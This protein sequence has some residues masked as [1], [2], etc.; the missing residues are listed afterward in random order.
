MAM[1][2]KNNSNKGADAKEADKTTPS[3][4]CCNLPADKGR[5]LIGSLIV[6]VGLG[7]LLQNI[8]PGF[9]FNYVWPVLIV[10]FGLYMMLKGWK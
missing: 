1:K 10:I 4:G 9:N 5:I 8:I 2:Q 7:L 3:I 6:I